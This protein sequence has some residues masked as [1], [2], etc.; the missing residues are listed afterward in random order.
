MRR[1]PVGNCAA[2]FFS[3]TP[4]QAVEPS[5]ARIAKLRQEINSRSPLMHT[6]P[7]DFNATVA[8]PEKLADLQHPDAAHLLLGINLEGLREACELVGFPFD[9][10]KDAWVT[11]VMRIGYKYT[12]YIHPEMAWLDEAYPTKDD[13]MKYLGYDFCCAV[14]TWLKANGHENESI[15]QVLLKRGSKNVRPANLFYS[16]TQ[17]VYLPHT[18]ER[19]REGIAAHRDKLPQPTEAAKALA[20]EQRA[21]LSELDALIEAARAAKDNETRKKLRA[22]QDTLTACP[23]DESHLFFWLGA[24]PNIDGPTL[25]RT[26]DASRLCRG[27]LHL[28]K[29]MRARFRSCSRAAVDQGDRPHAGGARY[30][31]SD[32]SHALLLYSRIAGHRPGRRRAARADELPQGVRRDG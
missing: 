14:K 20:A 23:A 6:P 18:I 7:P 27:R 24:Q 31:P 22:E 30:R 17:G 4:T 10:G 25:D 9:F 3:G 28:A 12:R 19:M 21:R 1:N 15:C 11:G 29:T 2:A 5:S 16:H 32:L 8:P 26:P 13:F